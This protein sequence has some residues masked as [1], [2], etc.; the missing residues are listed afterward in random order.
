MNSGYTIS[1]GERMNNYVA[2]RSAVL[3]LSKDKLWL[4]FTQSKAK[5]S[6]ILWSFFIDEKYPGIL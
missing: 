2:G 4:Q 3:S 5:G 6:G 1:C